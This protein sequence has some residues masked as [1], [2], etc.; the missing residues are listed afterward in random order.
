VEEDL[1]TVTLGS[2]ES[3]EIERLFFG[4]IDSAGR[5]AVDAFAN[6]QHGQSGSGDT[7]NPLIQF[8]SAQK[9][10]TPKGL[11]WLRDHAKTNDRN[12]VLRHMVQ[13]RQLFGAIW[14][15]SVWL[16]ADA[17]R[18][19]TKFLISDHPVTV[20]NRRCGPRSQWCRGFNDPD[21][22]L[23][24]THTIFPLSPERILL[25]TNLAWVRNPYQSEVT[26]RPNP[27]PFR[28]AMFSVLDIQTHRFLSEEEVR[29]INFIIK[30]RALRY[31][32]AGKEEWLYPEN[33]SLNPIGRGT[34]T[35]T[36]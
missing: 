18:S 24:G 22:W 34:G 32:A 13:L 4:V 36:C 3:T 7:L 6:F 20:Y 27:N 29:E 15:E 10:R 25:L 35:G 33:L 1:Y 26:T 9:L 31:V 23:N 16:I 5:A 14:T 8:M 21:I 17:S 12:L 30:T 11:A 19:E 2:I 28:N